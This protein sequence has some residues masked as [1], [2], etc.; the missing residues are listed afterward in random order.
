[1]RCSRDS[2]SRR[3]LRSVFVPFGGWGLAQP[4]RGGFEVK[5]RGALPVP[6]RARKL[7]ASRL[8]KFWLTF[9]EAEELSVP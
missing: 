1:M 6:E 9:S 4:V 5:D 8:A 7:V 3:A 2:T